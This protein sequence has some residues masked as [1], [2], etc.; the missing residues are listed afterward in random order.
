MI[1]GGLLT[2]VFNVASWVVGLFP[3]VD[4]SWLSDVTTSAGR[5]LHV[6]RQAN[7]FLPVADLFLVGGFFLAYWVASNGANLIRRLWSLFT[8][9][10]GA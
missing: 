5:L 9:G 2:L 7:E 6:L 10:G 3:T 4:M 1:L 8:G